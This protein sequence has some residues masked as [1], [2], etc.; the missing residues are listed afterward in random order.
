M[1]EQIIEPEVLATLMA[2]LPVVAN[3]DHAPLEGAEDPS[4]FGT[5]KWRTLFCSDRTATSGMVMGIAEFGPGDTLLPHR[6]GPAEIY[7][8]LSGQGTVTIDGTPHLMA[9]G[10][11]LYIPA[12]AEHGT[13]AGPDGLRFLYVFPRDKFSEVDYRFSAV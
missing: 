9:P 10:V 8:G 3:S 1:N 4:V 13:V 6:H 2:A 12:E 7:F 11:A 5:V